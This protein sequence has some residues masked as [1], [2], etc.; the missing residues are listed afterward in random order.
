ML[1]ELLLTICLAGFLVSLNCERS[2]FKM[3][4]RYNWGIQR[5]VSILQLLLEEA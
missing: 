1:D 5:F 4:T 3:R 2:D